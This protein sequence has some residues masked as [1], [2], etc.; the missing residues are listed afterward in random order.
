MGYAMLLM[1]H[2]TGVFPAWSRPLAHHESVIVGF[3]HP[4]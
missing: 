1:N 3:S 2:S 4:V